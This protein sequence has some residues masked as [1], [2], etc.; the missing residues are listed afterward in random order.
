MKKRQLKTNGFTIVELLIVVVVIA[1]LAA[2][3]IVAYNGIANRA[4][5]ASMQATIEQTMKQVSNYKTLNGSYPTSLSVLNNNEGPKAGPDIIF[6]YTLEG[7]SDYCLTIATTTSTATFYGCGSA[8]TIKAGTY[9]GHTSIIGGGGYPTRGGF[10]NITTSYGSGDTMAVPIGSI[11]DGSWMIAVFTT[12]IGSDFTAPSGWTA[13]APRKTTNTLQT[14]LFAKIKQTGDAASQ[15]FESPGAPGS[16]YVNAALIWGGNATPVASWV[17][18]SFGDRSVNATPTTAVTPTI[19]TSAARSLVLSIATERTNTDEANYVSLTGA[20]PWVWIPQPTG[21]L[22]KNQTI[23]IGYSEQ[24]TAG[25]TQA[26]TVTYPNSQ[27]NNA[28]AV[29][30]A[31]PPAG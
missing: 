3:T 19:T 30:V 29:Q 2:I 26:M 6:A 23:T 10:T 22:S 17:V 25:T 18:G 28:T 4:R 27:T 7:A 15:E 9:S 20:T 31:I 11:P 16:P 14:S 21:D 8:G 13:L 24:A 5:Q 1:I 12:Y